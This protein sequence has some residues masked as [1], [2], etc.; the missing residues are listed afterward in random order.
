[1]LS[2]RGQVVQGGGAQRV[3]RGGDSG[4]DL[5]AVRAVPGE[6]GAQSQPQ[7]VADLC[8]QKHPAGGDNGWRARRKIA[9]PTDLISA[10]AE[11]QPDA[12]H[13][14]WKWAAGFESPGVLC[15]DGRIAEAGGS[16]GKYDDVTDAWRAASYPLQI[17]QQEQA[18]ADALR[19]AKR[20]LNFARR[21]YGEDSEEYQAANARRLDALRKLAEVLNG[22]MRAGIR[23][24]AF[25]PDWAEE[26]K[27][28]G[29]LD[30]PE[31]LPVLTPDGQIVR[32]GGEE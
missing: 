2:V 10:A 32:G 5:S 30:R 23:V 18:A 16:I 9:S 28:L 25:T 1:M 15:A 13:W 31:A 19:E 11:G 22:M 8:G 24:P 17:Y 12:P 21:G 29:V 20:E 14:G 6:L 7:G 3:K 27:A 26:L 4:P